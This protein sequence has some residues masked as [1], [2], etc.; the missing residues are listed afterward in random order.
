MTTEIILSTERLLLKGISPQV[1][2]HLFN[3]KTK[4]EIIQF[5]AFDE[6]GYLHFKNMHEKGMETYS[7]SLFFF[8]L[9][10]KQTNLPIGE[11]GFHTW[12]KKH[13][14]A[15]AFYLLR[16]DADK[17]K[18]LMSEAFPIVLKYGFEEMK[19]HRV[20]AMIADWNTASKKLLLKNNFKKEG[21]LRED[22]FIDGSNQDSDCYSLLKWEWQY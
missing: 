3:N 20:A 12:N 22:Y 10:D 13:N 15:D 19:L 5:F 11:C 9:I 21:T 6:A 4:A 18:G 1:I 2:H 14:R 16:N 7:L 8:L 17:Q